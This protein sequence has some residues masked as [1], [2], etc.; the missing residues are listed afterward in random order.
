MFFD[1]S[2]IKLDQNWKYSLREV[3]FIPQRFLVASRPIVSHFRPRRH[4]LSVRVY[5]LP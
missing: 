3:G 5:R 1:S 2:S 4:R